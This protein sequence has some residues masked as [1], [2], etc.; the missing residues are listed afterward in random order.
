MPGKRVNRINLII[1]WRET[2]DPVIFFFTLNI[3]NIAYI[4]LL[5]T[6]ILKLNIQLYVPSLETFKI[7]LYERLEVKEQC[8]ITM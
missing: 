4:P 6:K 8:K 5:T 7:K 1:C 2:R 3:K